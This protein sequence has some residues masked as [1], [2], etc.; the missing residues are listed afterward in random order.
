M[1]GI[2]YNPADFSNQFVQNA[3]NPATNTP[4]Q[5][6][7][8]S[9]SPVIQQ[10]YLGTGTHP[11]LAPVQQLPIQ[12]TNTSQADA[13]WAKYHAGEGNR[14]AGYNGESGGNTHKSLS[15]LHNPHN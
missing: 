7:Y 12:Q 15:N 11:Q 1:A 9:W 4:V 6:P 14:P 10:A 3:L 8:Q 2:F 13:D 5:T